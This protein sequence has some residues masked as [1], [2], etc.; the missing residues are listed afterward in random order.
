[1]KNPFAVIFRRKQTISKVA[2]LASALYPCFSGESFWANAVEGYCKNSTVY[3]CIKMVAQNAS[4]IPWLLYRETGGQVEEV[5][6]HQAKKLLARPHPKYAFSSFLEMLITHL[7]L[8]G[9]AYVLAVGPE[10]RPPTELHL[11]RPDAVTPRIERG[12]V[13]EY[14]YNS[15]AGKVSFSPEKVLHLRFF[16]PIDDTTGVSP[17][18]PVALLIDHK[19]TGMLWNLSMLLNGARPGGAL[20]H[21]GQLTEEQRKALKAV[22]DEYAGPKGAGKILLLTGQFDWKELGLSAKDMDWLEALKLDTREIALTLGV[23]PQLV[24]DSANL[25]YSNYQEARK[26]F[27]QETIIPLLRFIVGEFN[28]WLLHKLFRDEA[29]F[30]DLD[31]DEVEALRENRSELWKNALDGVKA[32]ILTINEA[33][34]L[35]GYTR[36]ESREADMLYIP[37]NVVPISAPVP[38][39]S[40]KKK[41][42]LPESHIE[43]KW[44]SARRRIWDPWERK[45]KEALRKVFKEQEE[46][47]LRS[48]GAKQIAFSETD[49]DE[50]LAQVAIPL[51]ESIVQEGFE[52]A[53]GD[54]GVDVDYEQHRSRVFQW[55][56]REAGTKIKGINDTT[57]KAIREELEE[58][59]ANG[60]GIP[61]LAK[62]VRNVFEF[63]N[64]QR[65]E[66]IARTETLRAYRHGNLELYEASGLQYGQWWVAMDERT[67]DECMSLH[68]QTFPLDEARELNESIHPNCRCVILPVLEG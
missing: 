7:Y 20:I 31:L 49:W 36:F 19:N 38:E 56:E 2:E 55:V 3:R 21:Q 16:S 41:F 39:K 24:G 35:L 8:A 18:S 32:G 52:D 58:G 64:R 66:V 17:I 61:E 13:V 45:W 14:A 53:K 51:L 54:L 10:K 15:Q 33:R 65:S 60:E 67:C 50:K 59:I 42:Y 57:L 43:Q 34:E 30:F 23:P 62:R 37:L 44:E 5:F 48:I 46:E 6:E 25:T 47:V 27:Y 12:E 68:G 11:L 22:L 29:L 28:V 26:S 4:A 1:M 63:A 9:N 40:L